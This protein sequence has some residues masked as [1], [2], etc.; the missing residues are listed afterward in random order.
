MSKQANS[1]ENLP[2][3]KKQSSINHTRFPLVDTSILFVYK[4]ALHSSRV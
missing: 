1:I 3:I 4:N 2:F